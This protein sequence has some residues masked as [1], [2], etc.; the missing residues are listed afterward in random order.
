MSCNGRPVYAAGHGAGCVR[1][2]D[3]GPGGCTGHGISA[4]GV[5]SR[6]D[7]LWALLDAATLRRVRQP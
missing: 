5:C 3:H 4:R 6:C 2:V 1:Y 7:Y